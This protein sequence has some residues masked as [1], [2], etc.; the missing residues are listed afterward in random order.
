MI[1]GSN[2]RYGHGH[3]SHGAGSDPS[4]IERGHISDHTDYRE[5]SFKAIVQFMVA[6]FG[7]IVFSYLSMYGMM[8]V[9][10]WEHE[11]KQPP[12][13]PV[14]DTTWNAGVKP[15]VQVAPNV[16][17]TRYRHT[18]DSILKG[19]KTGVMSIDEAIRQVASEGLPYRQE[20]AANTTAPAQTAPGDTAAAAAPAGA[21]TTAH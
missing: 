8:K 1:T 20:T 15:D 17:L 3:G 21:D 6:L 16:D 7:V 14:A 2:K 11:D 13:S 18:Q 9:F 4:H 10:Q 5:L 12:L 19:E